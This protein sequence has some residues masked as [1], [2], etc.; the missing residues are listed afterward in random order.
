MFELNDTKTLFF[1]FKV[2][3]DRTRHLSDRMIK[4]R[5][6]EQ[7]KSVELNKLKQAEAQRTKDEDERRKEIE[8]LRIELQD[9]KA[10]DLAE[11]KDVTKD[12]RRRQRSVFSMCRRPRQKLNVSM[13]RLFF[14]E[15]KRRL[16]RLE[17]K[18]QHEEKTL[19][20]KIALE[21]RKMLIAHRKLESMRL[22]EEL[23]NRV[24]VKSKEKNDEIRKCFRL[25]RFKSLRKN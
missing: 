22:L 13:F 21:E 6:I 18:R 24:K 3:F 25:F 8:R 20:I 5:R 1:L 9:A 16:K 10:N 23:F 12:T 15:E 4:K 19:A 17:R 7:M 2:D 14:R 11:S